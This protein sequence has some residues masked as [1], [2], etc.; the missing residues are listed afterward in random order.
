MF[1]ETAD[2]TNFAR[3]VCAFREY[4][5]R[6]YSQD[7]NGQRI[8]S[9][10]RVLVNSLL[11]FYTPST[12]TGRYI[13]YNVE[14]GKEYSDIVDSTKAISTYAPITHIDS[15]SSSF[16]ISIKKIQD[17]FKPIKLKDLGS[18]ARLTYNPELP[19]EPDLALTLFPQKQK[20]IIGYITT[21]ELDDKVYCFNYVELKEEPKK[22]FL[23]YLGNVGKSPEFTDT[24]QHGFTYLPVIRLK[25]SHE[26]F[27]LS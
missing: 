19:E 22:L 13:S 3:Y 9:T 10:R 11:L 23:K 12:K 16:K 14:G 15:L 4:P 20:W 25:K 27:G 1:I 26:I 24:F 18:L 5:L 21:L 2:F 8:L 6:V 17:K 7:L